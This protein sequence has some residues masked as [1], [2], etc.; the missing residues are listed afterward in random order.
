M[1]VAYLFRWPKQDEDAMGRATQR[2]EASIGPQGPSGGIFH[3]EGPTSDGGWWTFNIWDED[4]SFEAF[5]ANILDP[6]LTDVGL[7]PSVGSVERLDVA[8]DTTR[9]GSPET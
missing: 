5:R 1:A 2:I 7:D 4:A 8:W 9:M 3:A 6:A